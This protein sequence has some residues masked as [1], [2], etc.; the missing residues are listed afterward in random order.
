MTVQEIYKIAEETAG[1]FPEKV[2][3]KI[4]EGKRVY[5][6]RP[7]Q[8]N[9]Y[10]QVGYIRISDMKI[11]PA[12]GINARTERDRDAAYFLQKVADAIAAGE[13]PKKEPEEF[14]SLLP[15]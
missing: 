1:Q 3:V 15:W 13:A 12:F 5:L 6:T 2:E 14:K 11:F 4:W 10:R 7:E 9:K 8:S